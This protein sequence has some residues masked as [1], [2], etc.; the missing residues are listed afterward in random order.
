MPS[1]QPWRLSP[2][3]ECLFGLHPK[4]VLDIGVG[5]GKWGALAREYTDVNKGRCAKA[6]WQ[7]RID[8]IEIFPAYKSVLWEAYTKVYIGNAISVLPTLSNYDLIM[9]VEVLEHMKKEDGLSLIA[10]IKAK[11][12]NFIVSYSNSVSVPV[13]GNKYEQHISKWGPADFPGCRLLCAS[14]DKISEVYVGKGS[15]P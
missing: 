1:S 3:A 5:F 8:G 7:V 9:A 10:A 13:F 12:R 6:Q 11:S 4:S 2:I 14:A 15:L